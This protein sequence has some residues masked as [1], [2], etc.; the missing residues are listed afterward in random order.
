[1][2]ERNVF[3]DILKCVLLSMRNLPAQKIQVIQYKLINALDATLETQKERVFD[4]GWSLLD[5]NGF[6]QAD[7]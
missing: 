7:I 4:L 3:Q 5:T 2:K 6:L 1:M